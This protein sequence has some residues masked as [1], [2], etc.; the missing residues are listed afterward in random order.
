MKI[1][2]YAPL[3]ISSQQFATLA[4]SS[5][6]REP[7]EIAVGPNG[8]VCL[9]IRGT[10]QNQ[11]KFFIVSLNPDDLKRLHEFLGK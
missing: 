4:D 1:V 8:D 10:G 9:E 3:N 6:Y 5:F 2:R 11:G 7:Y